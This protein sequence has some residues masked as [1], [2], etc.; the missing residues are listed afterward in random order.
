MNLVKQKGFATTQLILWLLVLLNTAGL[1]CYVYTNTIKT[2]PIPNLVGTWQGE[3]LTISDEKGYK[4]RP[5]S[6]TITEQQDRR[7]RG[8]FIYAD[9]TKHFF[10]VIYPDN[11]T[12]T[13]VST[14]S[15][16]F[17]HGQIMGKD[18][19]ATCYLEA[20]EKATAGCAELERD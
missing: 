20:F 7:F 12:F 4:S 13:W 5:K 17:V 9:G 11:E 16:G 3:N 10:G 19:I 18:K 15:K 1:A 2:K 14:P 8:T 6:I